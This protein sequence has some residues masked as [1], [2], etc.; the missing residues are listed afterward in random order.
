MFAHWSVKFT[1]SS[2]YES[3]GDLLLRVLAKKYLL[4]FHTGSKT[5]Q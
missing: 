1:T 4:L 5:V 3:S 2:L